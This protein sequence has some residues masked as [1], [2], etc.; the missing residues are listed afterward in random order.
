MQNVLTIGRQLLDK[1][2]S[3]D[4][5]LS[6]DQVLCI[7][8]AL[9]G[10]VGL[11]DWI[12]TYELSL[13]PFY[14]LV[15]VFVTWH[16]GW[17]WGLVFALVSVGNQIA[18]GLVLGHPFSRPAYFFIVNFNKLFSTLLIVALLTRLKVLHGREREHARID[19]L[20]G[21]LNY[22]GF[23]E[24]LT[25]EMARHRRDG[26]SFSVAYVDC[27]NFKDVNDRFG[28]KVGD[29]FLITI[30]RILKAHMRKTDFVARLGGDEFGLLLPDTDTVSVQGII[31]RLHQDLSARLKDENVSVTASIG[32]ATFKEVPSSED[33]VLSVAD[34]LMYRGKARGK[35]S[36]VYETVGSNPQARG[37]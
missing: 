31:T 4:A 33:E 36:V 23:H 35:N 22:K 2:L 7:G 18:I 37:Y 16:A 24:S 26:K 29:R 17:Q 11:A 15:V 9:F 5:A 27:D 19:F 28:H 13:N 25:L 20:T 21:A 32:V 3:I 34:E 30:V 8:A 14:L 10:L 6:R 1:A 12:T